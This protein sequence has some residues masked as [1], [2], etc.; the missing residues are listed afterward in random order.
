[1]QT[2]GV[3]GPRRQHAQQMPS[4]KP[5]HWRCL[6]PR[7]QAEAARCSHLMPS[8]PIRSPRTG[9]ISEGRGA[10]RGVLGEVPT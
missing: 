8:A 7:R 3:E 4:W 1:M 6:A 10:E 5:T 2:L 9:P